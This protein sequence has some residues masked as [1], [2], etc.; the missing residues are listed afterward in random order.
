MV[1]INIVAN[2]ASTIN[3]PN[4]IY[5]SFLFFFAIITIILIIA[6]IKNDNTDIITAVYNEGETWIEK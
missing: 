6:P 3:G 2:V 1:G 5:P 4:G